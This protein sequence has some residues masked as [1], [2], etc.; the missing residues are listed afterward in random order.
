MKRV[1]SL[2]IATV[3]LMILFPSPADAWPVRSA[4]RIRRQ[5]VVVRQKVVVAQPAVAA[6]YAAPVVA[7]PVYAAPAVSAQ[8]V[9]PGCSAFFVK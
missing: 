6:V 7:A 1:L 2:F 4:L 8:V 3:A 9:V 5:T